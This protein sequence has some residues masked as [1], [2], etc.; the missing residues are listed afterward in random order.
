MRLSVP[1]LSLAVLTTAAPAFAQHPPGEQGSRNI[2][3]V[4][5]MPLGG[6]AP[7]LPGS[8]N[9]FPGAQRM[10]TNEA[11]DVLGT[12]TAD[13]T[14]E[15]E[16]SRP[17]VYICHR[18]APTGFWIISI[19]EPS[20]PKVIYDWKIEQAELGRG[21][22]A[23]GPMYVKSHGRYYFLQTFQFQQ[24]G[25]HVDL[26]AIAFDVTGLP[27]TTKIKE[28]ARIYD[29]DHPGGF[30]ENFTY[31][32][33][34]GAAL[35]FTA[36]T[37]APIAHVYDVDQVVASQGKEG[38]VADVSLPQDAN[39][40]TAQ[41]LRGFHDYY[42][43]FDPATQTDRLYGAGA[44]GY[45]VYDI[46]DLKNPK[47]LTSITGIAGVQYGHTFVVD[48]TGRYAV[49]EVEYRFSPLRIFDMKPGLDGTVKTISRPIGAWTAN[50][51]NY[52][53][54]MEVRWPYVFVA[55]YDDGLQIFNM[56]DPTNPYTVGY[57]DTHDGPDGKPTEE[58]AFG[59]W[60]PQIRNAD[61]LIVGSDFIT[62]FWA[63]KMEG[64]AGWNGHQW[65][66]PNISSAQDWDNGP[67]GLKKA[68]KVS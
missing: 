12:R 67:D 41:A 31:K 18:F 37:A 54:N 10:V 26:G 22:G 43:A 51:K 39:P 34:S 44:G 8:T 23:L 16:L 9:P 58:K 47:L 7:L 21:S 11:V 5:H 35:M 25:P 53:H 49:T 50:W 64:F 32:H 19:K 15:Q 63:F 66:L 28:V 13:I 27:D 45:Y 57:Y 2:S 20:K 61:G 17:Y 62:G 4:A 40:S 6:A 55:A 48:P 24:G 14:M 1:V 30:H 42:A 38:L 52:A 46:T 60:S 65:G 3:I 36:V 33:S 56:M 59:M 68:A 29:K